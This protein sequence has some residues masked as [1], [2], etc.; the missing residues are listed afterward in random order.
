MPL[1]LSLKPGEKFVLNGA[2]VENGDRRAT[3]VLQNKASVLREKDIMHE[4]EVDTPAKR[5]YFPV[6]MM[7]LSSTSQDGLYDE[8][9]LRMTEFM[10]AV[11]SS[12]V[13]SECVSVSREVMAGEFYKALLR[14]RKLIQY[15]AKLLAG[16]DEA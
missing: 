7:Y 3:L 6:M 14:C 11:G 10:N 4:H 12:D 1:K 5:I 13:L 2:V 9:V 15:E 8:F 16:S